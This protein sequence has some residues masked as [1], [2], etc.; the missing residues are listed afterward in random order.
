MVVREIHHHHYYE[1]FHYYHS[2][3][4]DAPR[5]QGLPAELHS[6]TRYNY[7]TWHND[8]PQPPVHREAKPTI[9]R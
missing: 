2:G 4:G 3:K 1:A 8:D 7:R 6:E 5:P 9:I